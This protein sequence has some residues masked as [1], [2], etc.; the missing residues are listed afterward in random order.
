MIDDARDL[1]GAAPRRA[2]DPFLAACVVL[3]FALL[4][5]AAGLGLVVRLL[6]HRGGL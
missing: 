6:E 3:A 1:I 4:F 2:S 5:A